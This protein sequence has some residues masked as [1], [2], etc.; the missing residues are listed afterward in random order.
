M[1]L[2][3]GFKSPKDVLFKEDFAVWKNRMQVIQTVD[4]A[5]EG[6]EG[7]VGMVTKY[8]PD[9]KFKDIKN[10]S[11]PLFFINFTKG[12]KLTPHGFQSCVSSP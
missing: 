2:I 5:P 3:A 4:T 10:T 7:P 12:T 9:L 6:Y 8:I 11:P 1:T